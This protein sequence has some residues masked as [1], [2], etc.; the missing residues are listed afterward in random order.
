VNRI[1]CRVGAVTAI[2]W[3]ALELVLRVLELLELFRIGELRGVDFYLRRLAHIDD[4]ER[5]LDCGHQV[6]NVISAAAK[7]FALGLRWGSFSDT[8]NNRPSA[9]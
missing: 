8:A 1:I 9:H 5:G 2:A 4:G 6:G 3:R 7:N